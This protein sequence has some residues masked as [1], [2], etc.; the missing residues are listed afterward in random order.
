[1]LTFE[2]AETGMPCKAPIVFDHTLRC[3]LGFLE[4]GIEAIKSS[5]RSVQGRQ[6]RPVGAAGELVLHV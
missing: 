4:G 6:K 2:C 1:M 3:V 5:V